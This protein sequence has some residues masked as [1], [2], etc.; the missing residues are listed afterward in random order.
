M[1][2]LHWADELT[3]ITELPPDP[4]TKSDDD[5]FPVQLDEEKV[6]VYANKKSVGYSEYLKAA[7]AGLNLRL[8]FDIHTEEYSGQTLAE[9]DGK[10]YFVLRSYE[11][12]NGEITE[13]TLS[14]LPKGA[15][16]SG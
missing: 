16:S 11:L 14:D 9:H 4:Q 12:E 8:K 5:G 2:A 3:L 10:R 6:P 13:L 15:R 7:K 1:V